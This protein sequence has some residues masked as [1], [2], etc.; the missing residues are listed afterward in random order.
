M[1][2][3]IDGGVSVSS[4]NLLGSPGE[5]ALSAVWDLLKYMHEHAMS[6][7]ES[8]WTV[9]EFL[10]SAGYAYIPQTFYNNSSM[11][12]TYEKCAFQVFSDYLI[13]GQDIFSVS[14]DYA[15]G[16]LNWNGDTPKIQ[17]NFQN[18]AYEFIGLTSGDFSWSNPENSLYTKQQS[19]TIQL[20]YGANI[21]QYW[22]NFN[23]SGVAGLLAPQNNGISIFGGAPSFKMVVASNV[24][25]VDNSA[26]ANDKYSARIYIPV[27]P[28]E[29]Y[30]SQTIY[31]PVE[32]F[33]SEWNENNPSDTINPDDIP[34]WDELEETDPTEPTEATG[35]CGCNCTTIYVN[36]DG[37]LT[38]SNNIS[39]DY[40]L[41]IDNNADIN[42]QLTAAAGA[43]GAGAIVIDPDANINL[44]AG[45][46]GVGAFGAG[47]IVDPNVNISGSVSVGDISGSVSVGASEL[48]VDVSGGI[49]IDQ[50]GSTNT[51]NYNTYNYYYG[52]TED[53][54]EPEQEPFSI[55]YGEILGE[56]EL[57]SILTQETFELNQIDTIPVETDIFVET[58]PGQ[59]VNLPA[60]VVTTSNTV[61]DFG[62]G[63]IT[64]MGLLPVYSPLAI[65]SVVCYIL[66]GG[67]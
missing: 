19:Q 44:A 41:N 3:G 48:N 47:A 56:N 63:V 57:E 29:T 49:N 66:R 26:V 61:V 28:T 46:F 8:E 11:D 25:S 59:I 5:N 37:S 33:V 2:V 10:N 31:E 36:A 65:F 51:N 54:Q 23:S 7:G 1:P 40:T 9:G 42:L 20:G 55:D 18:H 17:Y 50:S 32:I 60:E 53:S 14:T 34:T 62:S 43:F 38:I 6:T 12:Y 22:Y 35:C 27:D 4:L 24:K 67:K 64:E 15:Q 45:A 30:N 58:I 16:I 52:T 13:Q 39:G 21:P